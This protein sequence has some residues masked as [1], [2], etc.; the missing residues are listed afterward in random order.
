TLALAAT[1]VTLLVAEGILRLAH[2]LHDDR[3]PLNV[4]LQS[5]RAQAQSS[6]L[7]LNLGDIVQPSRYAG[8]VYELR[9]NVRGRFMGQSI[10][11]NSRGLH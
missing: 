3:R 7:G 1:V 2:Y 9:P 6:L 4:Q 11:I 5:S 8:I 10:L